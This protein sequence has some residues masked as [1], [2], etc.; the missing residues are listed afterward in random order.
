MTPGQSFDSETSPRHRMTPSQSFDKN[1]TGD[2][3]ANPE[4]NAAM[5]NGKAS[6]G[7]AGAKNA[8]VQVN[9]V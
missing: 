3:S 6:D 2:Y 8:V 9:D 4:P 5:Q 1:L 7:N